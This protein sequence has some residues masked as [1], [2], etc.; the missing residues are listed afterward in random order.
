VRV[1]VIGLGSIGKRHVRNLLDLGC[2]VG[3]HDV[4]QATERAAIQ[5]FGIDFASGR[6]TDAAAWVI[7]T[8]YD[9]HLAWV[10]HAI[11][12]R[13]PMFIEKPLGSLEQLPHW[14]KVAAM[15]LPITQVGYQC[16]FH[17]AVAALLR[18]LRGTSG[19]FHSEC[20]MRA[21]PGRAYGPQL[22]ECS[23][24]L[25]LALWCGAPATVDR[26]ESD[27]MGC[28]IR[29]GRWSVSIGWALPV[30]ERSWNVIG[31][32][33]SGHFCATSPAALGDQ[34]YRDELAHFLDCVRENKPTL[35]PLADGLRV[36][37]VCAQVEAL[38]QSSV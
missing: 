27:E 22:L 6:L 15:D 28:D 34:M 37:E 31:G 30:Y 38:S 5:E 32:E 3:G 29:L 36:L 12:L 24:D 7:A 20:N 21:W 18:P 14:R 33:S 25:D 10:A 11:A 16:R 19:S 23:H 9:W 4:D 13:K 17:P 1:A 35:C 8:P 2:E 26:A